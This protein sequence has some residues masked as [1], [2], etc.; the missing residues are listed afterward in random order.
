MD[1]IV[2]ALNAGSSSLKCALFEAGPEGLVALARTQID[3]GRG[4]T[5]HQAVCAALAWV[6]QASAGRALTGAG[7]RVVHGGTRF[8]TPVCLDETT[9]RKLDA[10]APLAPLHQPAA[11]EAIRAL[12]ALRPGLE[13]VACFDT[14]FHWDAPWQA[15]RLGLPREL[16]EAGV[17]RYGFHGLN[18]QHIADRLA[19]L[20][21]A[22]AAGRV[23]AAHLGA[24]SSLCALAG[25][26]SVETTMG[27]SPLD[28]LLMATR[29]GTLDPGVVL[30]L[31]QHSG[32][33]TD[34]VE[35]LLYH[36]SGLLGVSGLSDDM[37]TLL[38]SAEAAAGEAVELF[39]Y[40]AAMDVA[41]LAGVLGGLDG[42]VFTAGVGENSPEIRRRIAARLTWLGLELDEASNGQGGERRIS[43][44]SSRVAVWVIPADEERVI[45]AQAILA[46]DGTNSRA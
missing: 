9:I 30:Y 37:R 26:R 20:D 8:H 31:Q 24:G 41:A 13:Q 15:Q 35:D 18:Y 40:R 3:A 6:E 17:R 46:L 44:G 32:M 28:G 1:R 29:C 42:L 12:T 14:A 36:R 7:H 33:T 22:P 43:T 23:V 39:V 2:L 10:L 45:A 11:I 21:P 5:G 27:F 16:H 19:A 34:E 25:G 4:Q 38:A